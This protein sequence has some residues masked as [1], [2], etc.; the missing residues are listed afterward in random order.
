[1]RLFDGA[2]LVDGRA[3]GPRLVEQPLRGGSRQKRHDG[4]AAGRLAEDRDVA[5]VAAERGDVV[6]HPL[7]RGHLV[8]QPRVAAAL[9][10]VDP[11]EVQEAEGPESVVD[12]HDHHVAVLDEAHQDRFLSIP[13]AYRLYRGTPAAAP[14]RSSVSLPW[15][16]ACGR[17]TRPCF[18]RPL[19][20]TD[21]STIMLRAGYGGIACFR[22]R[23]CPRAHPQARVGLGL[24]R[25]LGPLLRRLSL[26]EFRH[27]S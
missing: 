18:L 6:A 14:G 2:Q 15:S 26:A 22:S 19:R 7:E 17:R 12:R 8:E 11:A 13:E 25:I 3:H 27:F 5:R 1:M 4:R 21:S 20:C 24:A 10:R 9:G 16:V 23:P